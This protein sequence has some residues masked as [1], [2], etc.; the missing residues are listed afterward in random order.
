MP[1]LRRAQ[2]LRGKNLAVLCELPSCA[3]LLVLTSAA[4]ALGAQ[5]TRI[6]PSAAQLL[7]PAQLES[8]AAVLGRLYD[9][10]ECHHLP[11]HLVAVL[12]R[13]SLKPVWSEHDGPTSA[14]DVPALEAWLLKVLT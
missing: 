12:S 2:L 11:E 14:T 7:D 8:M 6:R 3:R 1:D 10:I 9:A 13:A 5:V 4:T